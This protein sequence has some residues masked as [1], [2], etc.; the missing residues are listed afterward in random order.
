M[1]ANEMKT[2]CTDHINTRQICIVSCKL[3]SKLVLTQI[4]YLAFYCKRLISFAILIKLS[5]G[6]QPSGRSKM[7]V[8]SFNVCQMFKV[9]NVFHLSAT[10]GKTQAYLSF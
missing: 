4:S 7:A 2:L 1:S 5:R 6:L 10:L 9:K 8:T 3:T